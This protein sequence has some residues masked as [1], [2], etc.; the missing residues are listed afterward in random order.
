MA[1][2]NPAPNKSLAVDQP[3]LETDTRDVTLTLSAA[4][5]RE[6]DGKGEWLQVGLRLSIALLDPF[7]IEVGM[8]DGFGVV[9]IGNV[10]RA[11]L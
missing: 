7:F 9:T 3:H 5:R 2:K 4:C 1:R 8:F 6:T 11:V 10:N